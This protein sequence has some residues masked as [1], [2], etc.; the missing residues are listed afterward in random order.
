MS[1]SELP[2][3]STSAQTEMCGSIRARKHNSCPMTYLPSF[4]VFKVYFENSLQ[5]SQRWPGS[6]SSQVA[7]AAKLLENVDCQL[8][9]EMRGVGKTQTKVDIPALVR[10]VR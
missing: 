10:V 9:E 8:S 7:I 3:A 2:V 4:F 5:V 1:L 6:L